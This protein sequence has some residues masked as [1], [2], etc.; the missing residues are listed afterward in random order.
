MKNKK[1]LIKKLSYWKER[2]TPAF[3]RPV[4]LKAWFH[5]CNGRTLN[6]DPPVTWCDKINWIKLYGVTDDMVRLSDKYLV[7][8]WV[9]EKLGEDKLIPLIGVWD[10]FEDIDFSSFPDRFVLK[11]NHA[12]KTNIV[13]KDKGKFDIGE[14]REKFKK[15]MGFDFAFRFGFQMQYSPIRRRIIAEEYI[16]NNG[17]D[18]M[19]YKF[20]CFNGEP[21]CCELIGGRAGDTRLAFFD[22][23]WNLLPYR[24]DAYP[25]YEEI[26]EKPDNY[27]ELVS[28]A[29][30]LSKGFPYVRVDLYRLDNGSIKFGEMTFT[31]SSG[32]CTWIPEG[33]D[34]MLGKLIELPKLKGNGM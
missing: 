28:A 32:Q 13:V 7:R 6:L 20:H 9:R 30:I 26:P 14:A 23:E 4:V 15:W 1:S 18:L 21:L 25:L 34:E 5:K 19:D 22:R 27:G 29:E 24:T 10:R 3:L 2:F 17:N 16:E 31:P 8:D 12:S 11:A 33:T